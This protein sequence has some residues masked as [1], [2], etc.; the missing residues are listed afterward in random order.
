MLPMAVISN[1][2]NTYEEVKAPWVRVL[3]LGRLKMVISTYSNILLSVSLINITNMRVVGGHVRPLG[4]FE[5]LARNI[6][7]RGTLRPYE[8]RKENNPSVYNTFST[9]TVLSHQVGDTSTARYSFIDKNKKNR[10]IHTTHKHTHIQLKEKL[11]AY[12]PLSLFDETP[13]SNN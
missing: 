6:K 4:L 12:F 1:A 7:R 10:V 5:V 8:K 2:S 9:T 13:H 3:P 11:V